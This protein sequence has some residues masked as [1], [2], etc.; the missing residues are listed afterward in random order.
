MSEFLSSAWFDATNA[1][2]AA[3][4]PT[5]LESDDVVRVVLELLDE[6]SGA[7]HALTLTLAPEGARVEPG[8]H[9]AAHSVV[10]LRY[11]DARRVTTGEVD[12]A[13]LLREGRLK[14]RGDVSHLVGALTWLREALASRHGEVVD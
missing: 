7:P 8:D 10:R 12:G 13:T 14:L 4:G 9:L 5:R 3:A 2:L 6:P 11:D 1:V